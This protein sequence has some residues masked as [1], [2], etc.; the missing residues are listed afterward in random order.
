M[1]SWPMRGMQIAPQFFP[2]QGCAT[3]TQQELFSS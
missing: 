2:A 3:R 1:T